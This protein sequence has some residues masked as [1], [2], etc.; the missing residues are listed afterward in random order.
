[1]KKSAA[2]PQMLHITKPCLV[3]PA[4]DTIILTAKNAFFNIKKVE[5]TAQMPASSAGKITYHSVRPCGIL[6]PKERCV[7]GKCCVWRTT[8]RWD[9]VCAWLCRAKNFM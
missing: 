1:M 5:K 3:T 7:C 2:G 4:E 8:P 9:G 6:F